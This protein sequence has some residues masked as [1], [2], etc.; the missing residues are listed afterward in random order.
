MKEALKKALKK[1]I[2]KF[3]KKNDVKGWYIKSTFKTN[4]VIDTLVKNKNDANRMKQ[5]FETMLKE[6]VNNYQLIDK[7]T[8][9]NCWGY[10]QTYYLEY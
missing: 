7:D 9:Y 5:E 8:I 2:Q 6:I 3:N 1:A 10:W 4:V